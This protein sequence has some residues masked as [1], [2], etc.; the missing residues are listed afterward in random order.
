MDILPMIEDFKVS[1]N[2]FILNQKIL[3]NIIQ[4]NIKR[5]YKVKQTVFCSIQ[6]NMHCN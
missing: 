3:Y 1:N 5:I 6:L 4:N 2:F